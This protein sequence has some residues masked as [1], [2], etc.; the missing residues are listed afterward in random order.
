MSCA[1]RFIYLLRHG[2]RFKDS[3]CFFLHL[4]P[5]AFVFAIQMFAFGTDLVFYFDSANHFHRGPLGLIFIIIAIACLIEASLPIVLAKAFNHKVGVSAAVFSIVY[6]MSSMQMSDLDA[7]AQELKALSKID[8][9]SQFS[10]RYYGEKT[11]DDELANKR[12][13]LF[14]I[15]DLG[16]FKNI[17]DNYGHMPGNEGLARVAKIWKEKLKKDNVVMRLAAM[18][19]QRIPPCPPKRRTG[20]N[21][22]DS[23]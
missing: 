10:N 21:R 5:L 1:R 19:S 20:R 22:P 17:N 13:C 23:F 12:A 11:I 16:D 8:A 14:A 15:I 4:V 3:K 6:F 18:D 7:V 2:T 9:L